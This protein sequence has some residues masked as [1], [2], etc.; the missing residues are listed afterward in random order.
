MQHSDKPYTMCV[1]GAEAG[2]EYGD[3]VTWC[4]EYSGLDCSVPDHRHQCCS[5]CAALTTTTT[6]TT[7]TTTTTP[8]T[9]T[10]TTLTPT[11]GNTEVGPCP[12]GDQQSFCSTISPEDCYYYSDVCCATCYNYNTHVDGSFTLHCN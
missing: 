10:T 3:R 8:S 4:S 6:T 1:G 5:T 9:T 12:E 11:T 7:S 2:C